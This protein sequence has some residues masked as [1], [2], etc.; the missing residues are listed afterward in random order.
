[1]MLSII[2]PVYNAEKYVEKTIQSVSGQLGLNDE[3]IMIDDGS[4]D[5][6]FGICESYS[7][8]DSRIRALHQ[9]NGGPSK[10]RN[11]GIAES[12]GD[13]ILFIDSDDSVTENWLPC[14][15]DYILKYS[16]DVYCFGYCTVRSDHRGEIDMCPELLVLSSKEEVKAALSGLI[17]SF[18]FNVVWNKAYRADFLKKNKICFDETLYIGEDRKFCLDVVTKCESWCMI[19]SSLY[20][21]IVQN[22]NSISA[23]CDLKRLEQML[24]V[25]DA[26]RHALLQAKIAAEEAEAYVI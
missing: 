10:A 23:K 2:M 25:N 7:K 13:Y 18:Y 17:D 8:K 4:K 3:L 22:S 6:S 14:I 5:G 24:K 15:R 9:E 19:P 11:I 16:A 26:Y 20:R 1:M 12:K 21:Y